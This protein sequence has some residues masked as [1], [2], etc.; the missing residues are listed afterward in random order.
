MTDA[1]KRI[2]DRI[3]GIA[4][5][6]RLTQQEI[7]ETIGLSRTQVSERFNGKVPWT[8]TEVYRLANHTGEPVDRFFP[9][10]ITSERAS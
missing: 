3:R 10:L 6:N 9:A 5:E 8:A 1:T 7:A 4:A 2:A